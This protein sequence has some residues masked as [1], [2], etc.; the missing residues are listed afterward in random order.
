[1]LLYFNFVY[2]NDFS[3][4]EAIN[5]RAAFGNEMP[6]QTVMSAAAFEDAPR[7][8]AQNGYANFNIDTVNNCLERWGR[9]IMFL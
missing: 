8:W 4:T 2:G 3:S 7:Q 1:M 6:F 5:F 9:Q